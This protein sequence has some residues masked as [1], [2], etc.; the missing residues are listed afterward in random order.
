MGRWCCRLTRTKIR[1][2][3]TV[4]SGWKCI[5]RYP[6]HKLGLKNVQ[7]SLKTPAAEELFHSCQHRELQTQRLCKT[8]KPQ[9]Q[10]SPQTA[11]Q[12]QT[13]PK[14]GNCRVSKLVNRS[15]N[16]IPAGGPAAAAGNFLLSSTPSPPC[17]W[18]MGT[19][20]R[21]EGWVGWVPLL[22]LGWH[23]CWAATT[24]T[25]GLARHFMLGCPWLQ[26]EDKDQRYV[27]LPQPQAGS[28]SP[29]L[30]EKESGTLSK[31]G[32]KKK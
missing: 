2:G 19:Q 16:E 26:G 13:P 24:T 14:K 9:L 25:A 17:R 18:R 5:S 4:T 15:E 3:I 22:P 27:A 20:E 28:V 23:H 21:R 10:P 6:A 8:E 12:Q 1:T 29:L 11:Q 31:N 7:T 30:Q 32:E